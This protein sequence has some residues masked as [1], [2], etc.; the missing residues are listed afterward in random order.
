MLFKK[1]LAKF[2]TTVLRERGENV[3]VLA[4]DMQ[5]YINEKQMEVSDY[6]NYLNRSYNVLM[7]EKVKEYENARELYRRL[8]GILLDYSQCNFEIRILRKKKQDVFM[9]QKL[10][11]TRKSMVQKCK[12]NYHF[13]IAECKTLIHLLN[14]A[15]EDTQYNYLI[16]F[17]NQ[18]LMKVI[19]E[20]IEKYAST[21]KYND[22]QKKLCQDSSDDAT[23][24][25]W[26]AAKTIVEEQKTYQKELDQLKSIRRQLYGKVEDCKNGEKIFEQVGS[27][28][29]QRMDALK[30]QQQQV[31]DRSKQLYKDA[32]EVW[33]E[34][35][36]KSTECIDYDNRI[37]T[38][39]REVDL[40]KKEIEVRRE[41][42]AEKKAA[43]EVV[44]NVQ[45]DI[46]SKRD[47][48]IQANELDEKQ[49][50]EYIA[51][52]KEIKQRRYAY[53]GSAAKARERKRALCKEHKELNRIVK[54]IK[55][56]HKHDPEF[57]IKIA[58]LNSLSS[59]ID[60]AQYEND[61]NMNNVEDC[62]SQCEVIQ[63]QINYYQTNKDKRNGEIDRYKKEQEKLSIR[64]NILQEEVAELKSEINVLWEKQQPF[65]E[66]IKKIRAHKKAYIDEKFR[67]LMDSCK[68][69]LEV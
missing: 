3:K 66:K 28:L 51:K 61:V 6:R 32:G 57:D 42:I 16:L 24:K 11:N 5:Q 17:Q 49:R 60:N 47:A 63:Q 4:Q 1:R 58:R 27:V 56:S 12:K 50:K 29:K 25:A 34:Y 65:Y 69:L 46:K 26:F 62:N 14:D 37:T 2:Y 7:Q 8:T 30:N 39:Q 36:S 67:E 15:M 68:N 35:F 31:Y 41:K 43:L 38:I 64:Y 20:N 52:I 55:M 22:L 40:L 54:V 13:S 45:R 21:V 48:L 19:P 59:D 9:D 23:K 18:E 53:L 44:K 10:C 33:R